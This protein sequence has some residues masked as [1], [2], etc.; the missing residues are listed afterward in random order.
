MK[1]KLLKSLVFVIVVVV[2]FYPVISYVDYGIRMQESHTDPIYGILMF[3]ILWIG[4][5]YAI[6]KFIFYIV[7]KLK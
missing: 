3:P 5:S 6:F 1:T 7:N 4:V 2:T